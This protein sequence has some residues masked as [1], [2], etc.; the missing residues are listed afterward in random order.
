[1]VALERPAER[2]LG[3][4]PDP[5]RHPDDGEV[6]GGEQVAGQVHAPLREVAD[7]GAPEDLSEPVVEQG[8]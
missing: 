6:R 2:L 3:V 5:A 7:R 8:A 1:V 4:V